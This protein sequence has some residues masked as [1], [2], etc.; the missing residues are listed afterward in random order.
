MIRSRTFL[1]AAAGAVAAATLGLTSFLPASASG[2]DPVVG[3]EVLNLLC[4]EDGGQPFFTPYA[5]GRC[6]E[7]PSRADLQVERTVC[8][9][10]LGGSFVAFDSSLRPNRTVWVCQYGPV[11]G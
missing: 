10:L 1:A 7:V 5:I 6:Q 11:D 4:R 9:G 2:G 8:E 3:R